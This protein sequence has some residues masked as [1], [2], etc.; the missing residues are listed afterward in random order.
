MLQ[1]QDLRK[2]YIQECKQASSLEQVQFEVR[3]VY[4]L[5]KQ[6][7]EYI[8]ANKI[9]VYYP[10]E[11]EFPI[12]PIVYD[13]WQDKKQC[14]LPIVQENTKI[15]SFGM[16]TANTKLEEQ[17][18]ALQTPVYTQEV[19]AQDLDFIFVPLIAFSSKGARLGH[20]RGYYDVTIQACTTR[21]MLIAVAYSWQQASELPQDPWDITMD[22]IVT[23]QKIYRIQ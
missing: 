3:R 5:V 10:K 6:L 8:Q 4:F 11:Y 19:S 15:L 14:Y 22:I 17:K 1:K 21:P 23:A 16:Y 12:L 2:R 7:P 20:G 13:L 18:F 9:G